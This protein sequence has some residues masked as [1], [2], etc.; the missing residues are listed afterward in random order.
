MSGAAADS[1]FFKIFSYKLLQG[2]TATALNGPDKIAISRKMAENF[3]GS[4]NAAINKT[5]RYN[6]S[7]VFL[8]SAVFENIP[9]NSSDQF[10]YVVNWPFHVKD[11]GWLTDWVLRHPK[12]YISLFPG[13]SAARVEMKIKNFMDVYVTKEK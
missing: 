9:V 10:D 5:I 4:A 3:F 8:I 11:V 6:N 12:T 2:N 7:S 1:D 13:A